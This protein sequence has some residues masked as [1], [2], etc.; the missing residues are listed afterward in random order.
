MENDLFRKQ[1]AIREQVR[2]F[3][4]AEL[5]PEVSREIDERDEYPSA[6]LSRFGDTGLL[7][8]NIP[9][10]YG[11][12]GGSALEVM[13]IYEEISKRLPVMAWVIGNIVLYGNDLIGWSG[14]AAQKGQFLPRLAQ[15]R[16][17]VAF[18]LTE[19]NAGSDA[20]SITTRADY[21]DGAYRINGSKMFI[22]GAGVSDIVVTLTRTAPARYR[23]ITA[24][25]VDTRAVGYRARPLK[26]L[27]YHGSNTCEV[28]YE[29]VRVAPDDILGGAEGLNQGWGQMVALL[30]NERLALSACALGIGQAV[31]DQTVAYAREHYRFH[32]VNGRY[33]AVQ[34]ALVEMATELEAA[35]RLTYHAAA[36]AS[37][38]EESVRETS[39]SK[40]FA[41]ETARKLA[42]RGIDLLGRDGGTYEHQIQRYLRDVLVLCIGGGTTQIQKN[43]IAKTMGLEDTTG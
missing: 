34:H 13:P 10:E 3:I 37:R 30:N 24:F 28:Y 29:N 5:T 39:M 23:G 25:M 12:M 42:L 22:T 9:R 4:Q 18:A 35:R 33:Q 1:E 43:I 41:T 15:G 40:Y 27:G 32:Q 2:A 11:G 38:R 17:K 8:V 6:L 21:V 14:S 20:A 7:S 36:Q 19:P 26:K 31:L 16:L